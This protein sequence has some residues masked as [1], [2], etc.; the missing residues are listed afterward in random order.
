MPGVRREQYENDLKKSLILTSY[1]LEC[2]HQQTNLSRLIE[3]PCVINETGP[4]IPNWVRSAP[5]V[6]YSATEGVAILHWATANQ[7]VVRTNSIVDSP[8]RQWNG[9]VI[10]LTKFLSL[11]ELAIV[12]MTNS[13]AA[14]GENFVKMAK[15][16][17]QY[18]YDFLRPVQ[19]NL[20]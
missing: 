20:E 19:H 4:R 11:A 5:V 7:W 1:V 3:N 13:G 10:I 12:E 8:D 16:S 17:F 6:P 18:R 2:D 15:F 9:N 14:S